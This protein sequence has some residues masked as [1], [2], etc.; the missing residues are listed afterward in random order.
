MGNYL[1]LRY[2]D[3]GDGTGELRTRAEVDGF[4]GKA[5]AYFGID[6]LVAFAES[7]REFPLP[8]QDDRRVIAGGFGN[9]HKPNEVAQEHLAISVY[10]VNTKRGYVGIQVRMATV[11]WPDMRPESQMKATVEL[12]TTYEPLAKFSKDLI[13]VLR[14]SL[15]EAIIEGESFR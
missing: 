10:P 11:H 15:H 1:R 4:S 8:A 14:G 5:K 2:S 3:D 7:L 6:E 9:L 13:A 12:L